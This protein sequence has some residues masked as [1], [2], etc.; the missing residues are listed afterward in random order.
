M[1]YNRSTLYYYIT[2]LEGDVI[3]LVDC[4][5]NTAAMYK[6]DPFGR[7]IYAVGSHAQINPLR[8]RSYYYDTETEMYYVSS[9]YYDPEV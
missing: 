2:N 3:K 9:R 7:E 5:G 6:Y 8:Y 1:L 4:Y